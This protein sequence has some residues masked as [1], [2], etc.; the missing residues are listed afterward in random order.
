MQDIPIVNVQLDYLHLQFDIKL[1]EEQSLIEE[2]IQCIADRLASVTGSPLSQILH[3]GGGYR[4]VTKVP[5]FTDLSYSTP[6]VEL[7]HLYIQCSPKRGG[8]KFLNVQFRGFPYKKAQWLCARLWLTELLGE[9]IYIEQIGRR[10]IR[11]HHKAIDLKASINS[12]AIDKPGKASAVYFNKDTCPK[13]FYIGLKGAKVVV[14]MYCRNTKLKNGSRTEVTRIEVKHY[15]DFLSFEELKSAQ[16]VEDSFK[17][18]KLYDVRMMEE[19]GLLDPWFIKLCKASGLKQVLSEL[20]K[21]ERRIIRKEISR[22][23]LPTISINKIAAKWNKH[24]NLFKILSPSFN[25]NRGGAK[26]VIDR[27]NNT[28]KQ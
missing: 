4:F 17:S 6:N 15:K 14:I 5:L 23:T 11:D 16:S 19:E 13:T 2:S 10:I 25:L 20:N 28:Y 22:Y 21:E 27:F 9:K 12:L 7:P 24:C 8:Y 18:I 1:L 26:S 3:S